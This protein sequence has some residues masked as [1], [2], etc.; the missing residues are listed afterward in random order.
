AE[1]QNL[2]AKREELSARIFDGL[3]LL[4]Q[5]SDQREAAQTETAKREALQTLA[6]QYE[7]EISRL[8][9][10]PPEAEW[11]EPTAPD[12]RLVATGVETQQ[13]A[14]QDRVR[15]AGLVGAMVGLASLFMCFLM[16]VRMPFAKNPN[17]AVF[18]AFIAESQSD[19]GG[20]STRNS[21]LPGTPE[22]SAAP[23]LEELE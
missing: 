8:R 13:L 2:D 15:N 5:L 10:L 17:R 1:V 16:I 21:E 7:S 12:E 4:R 9:E 22:F 20:Q 3:E 23:K 18:D 11:T 14:G 6:K 19:D